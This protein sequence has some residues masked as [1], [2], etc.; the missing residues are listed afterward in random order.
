MEHSETS[1]DT[2]C[3]SAEAGHIADGWE[4][5][6]SVLST[7][8]PKPDGLRIAGFQTFQRLGHNPHSRLNDFAGGK[9]LIPR[10]SNEGAVERPAAAGLPAEGNE[11]DERSSCSGSRPRAYN[12]YTGSGSWHWQRQ[13]R[14]ASD[15]MDW[16]VGR[17]GAIR[18]PGYDLVGV[19]DSIGARD[20]QLKSALAGPARCV[21]QRCLPMGSIAAIHRQ[22]AGAK[23]QLV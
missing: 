4:T 3:W 2:A 14:R 12:I 20:G 23:F 11:T 10:A 18:V 7:T 16:T 5:S 21:V 6:P 13:S 1:E 17:K 9:I 22:T 19:S 15:S 8:M